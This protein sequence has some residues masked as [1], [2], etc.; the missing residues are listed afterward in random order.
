MYTIDEVSR[1]AVAFLNSRFGDKHGSHKA[2]CREFDV[3]Q[4]SITRLMQGKAP[5]PSPILE[6]M[7]LERVVCYAKKGQS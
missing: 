2:I 7:G 1:Q 6:A 5:P 4:A 3:S